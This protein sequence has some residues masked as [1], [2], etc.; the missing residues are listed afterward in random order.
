MTYWLLKIDPYP[1][2]G[3]YSASVKEAE[4]H[5]IDGIANLAIVGCH[6]VVY[7]LNGGETG[8]LERKGKEIRFASRLI[9]RES[10]MRV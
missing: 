6:T 10:D 3:S 7:C 5:V 2:G 8:G 9:P 1:Q 4:G